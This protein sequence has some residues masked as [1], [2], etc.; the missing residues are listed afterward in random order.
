MF[1]IPSTARKFGNDV[2]SAGSSVTSVISN[3][4]DALAKLA[5]T[6]SVYADAYLTEARDDIIM[7]Q[8]NRRMQMAN[9]HAIR[10]A[11]EDRMIR[12][13]KDKDEQWAS[14]FEAHRNHLLA[15][16]SPSLKIAAE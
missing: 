13:R 11:D 15:L 16:V 4:A 8:D 3:S 9:K 14:D 10:R 1:N 12:E 5:E 7:G 6:G 2:M